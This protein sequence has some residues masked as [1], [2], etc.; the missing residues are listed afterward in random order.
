MSFNIRGAGKI[1]KRNEIRS[2]VCSYGIDM[3]CVQETKLEKFDVKLGRSLWG[4]NDC[5][6]AYR[7]SVGRSVACSRFGILRLSPEQALGT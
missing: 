7:E 3:C 6:W 4:N 5:E 1:I 2:L